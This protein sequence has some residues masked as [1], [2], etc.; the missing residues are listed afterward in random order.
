MSSPSAP[1]LLVIGDLQGC[2]DSLQ[3]LLRIAPPHGRL[4]FLGDLVN[5]GPASL[6]ALRRVRDMGE[7]AVTVLGNHDLHLLAVAEGIRPLHRDDTLQPVLD[8]PDAPELLAWLRHRPLAHFEQGALFVHAG[9]LPPWTAGRA[10]ELAGEV[11]R[12]LR[13]PDYRDFLQTMYGNEPARWDDGLAGNDR[14]RCILNALTRVR[15][16]D[17][18]G[19]MDLRPKQAPSAAPPGIVPWFDH[20]ARA[21]A[22]TPVVFGHWSTLGLM[23]RDDAVCLDSGCLWGG[24]LTALSWPQRTVYRVPCPQARPPR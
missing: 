15:Y 24:E 10:L 12:R 9:L 17:A 16:L 22:S 11:E 5:R 1:G 14:L 21:S 4:V 2:D 23:L 3:A 8:A 18:G 20:P 6:P 19:A 7:R 13:A